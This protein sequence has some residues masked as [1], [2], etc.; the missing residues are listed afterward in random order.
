[1]IN[2]AKSHLYLKSSSA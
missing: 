1:M 2:L